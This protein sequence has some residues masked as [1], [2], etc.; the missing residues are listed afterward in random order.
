MVSD[1]MNF[2]LTAR[3]IMVVSDR[4]NFV[5]TCQGDYDDQ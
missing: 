2:V 4:M 5:V 1:R 3:V